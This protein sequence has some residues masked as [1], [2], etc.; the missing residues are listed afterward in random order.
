MHRRPSASQ[1]LQSSRH[2]LCTAIAALAFTACGPD[3]PADEPKTE[4]ESNNDDYDPTEGISAMAEV[5]ALP[6]EQAVAAFKSSFPAI[7]DCFIDGAQRVEFLGGEIALSVQ[8]NQAAEAE[9]VFARQSTLGDRA[10]EECMIRALKQASWPAPVGGLVGVAENSFAFEMTGD[11]RPPVVM[12]QEQLS[13]M[14]AEN[15][16]AIADCKGSS[17]GSY[18]A[19]VYVDSNGRAM[20]AG[21]APSSKEGEA[22]SNCLVDVLQHATYPSP[23]SWAGKVTFRL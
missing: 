8:V 16:E 5:G 1:P 18:T 14:L 15:A 19:T 13:D 23:G 12:D 2:A 7:Q 22:N 9:Y 20:S 6:E 3:K 4:T 10:T 21:I 11:V 17:Y